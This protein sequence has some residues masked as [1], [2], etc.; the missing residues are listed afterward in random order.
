MLPADCA[1]SPGASGRSLSR[2]RRSRPGERLAPNRSARCGGTGRILPPKGKS[3]G[4][5]RRNGRRSA[6]Q[7]R[8]C[9]GVSGDLAPFVCAPLSATRRAPAALA[10][11]LRSSPHAGSDQRSLMGDSDRA[12]VG[13]ATSPFVA[14]QSR[15]GP[16]GGRLLGRAAVGEFPGS[17]DFLYINDK[18]SILRWAISV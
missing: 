18:K 13:A 7:P 3:G 14:K 10:A 4:G 1:T 2:F 5:R 9:L 12:G 15:D 8:R 16:P 17:D 6:A 11:Q